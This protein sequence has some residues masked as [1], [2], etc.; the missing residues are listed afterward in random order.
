MALGAQSDCTHP[1]WHEEGQGERAVRCCRTCGL[2]AVQ[3][4]PRKQRPTIDLSA[5]A[6]RSLRARAGLSPQVLYQ[7]Q[8]GDP[9]QKLAVL[10]QERR[11]FVS[12][13]LVSGG[14]LVLFRSWVFEP[15][16]TTQH[17]IFGALFLFAVYAY[18]AYRVYATTTEIRRIRAK[19]AD[20][21]TP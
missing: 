4:D 8:R 6:A 19:V 3:I 20:L 1:S 11:F 2:I 12:G 14:A 7:V 13:G 18:V 21:D 5:D 17:A 10:L 16:E 9:N 15:I